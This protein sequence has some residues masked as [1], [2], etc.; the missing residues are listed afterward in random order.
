VV[1]PKA[2][3]L[4]LRTYVLVA[5]GANLSVRGLP[6]HETVGLPLHRDVLVAS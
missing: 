5:G 4:L 3:S 6:A 2:H 1:L